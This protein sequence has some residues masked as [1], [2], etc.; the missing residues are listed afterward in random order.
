VNSYQ[1]QKTTIQNIG[2][3]LEK[4]RIK[5]DS[6]SSLIQSNDSTTPY[7]FVPISKKRGNVIIK[8]QIIKFS[9]FMYFIFLSFNRLLNYFII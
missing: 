5:N 6:R 4:K 2:T 1:E 9:L 3:E 8:R 7:D